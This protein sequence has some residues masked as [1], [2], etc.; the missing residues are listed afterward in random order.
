ML[1]SAQEEHRIVTHNAA[2]RLSSR[3]EQ[4]V[5]PEVPDHLHSPGHGGGCRGDEGPLEVICIILST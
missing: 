3:T 2:C 4:Y 1:E 5:L